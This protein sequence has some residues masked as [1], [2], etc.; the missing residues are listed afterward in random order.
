MS[1][2]NVLA[3]IKEQEVKFVDLRFTDTKGKEQHVSVPHHQ[4]DEGFFE[5]GKMFDGSSIAGWKGINESDMVLMPDASTALLDPFTEETTLIIRCDI[6]EPA[7]MQGYDRDPRSIAK[8]AEGFL[9]SSGIADTVLFGPEP[10]FF[11]FD[12]VRFGNTMGGSF[13]KVDAEE[14]AWN[15]ATEYEGGNKGHRPGVKG[16]YFPVAPVDSSQDLRSAMCLVLEEMGQVVEAHHHEVATAGQNEIATRFNTM[17]KKADEVQVQKYV[18]HNVAHAYG[19]TVTFMPKPMFGDNG[20]GMHCHQSLAK[21]GVNLFAGDLYGGLSETAL[22]YIGGIIK[23]AKA[24]NAFANPTTNSYKR[25]V[26]GYE[27]P[28]MLAYSARNRSASIRIPV[29]PSPKARRIEVRFP[30]PAANPYLAFAAQLMAGL[31]GIINK[32]HPGEAMDKNLYDLPP[33]EEALIPTVSG[34][35][36]EALK[37]LDADREFLTRGGVFTD[38]FIDSYLELKQVDVDRV[39]MTPHPVE[40]ELY[41]SV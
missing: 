24:I 32:I 30:D 9:K 38:D 8:R 33:E 21:D 37:S 17:T 16:G 23:H 19:K 31:D 13:F 27:A 22:F 20:S 29:V 41:Y 36:E 2:A 35:L 18:I 10:E 1:A 4:I 25:L 40:Y 28:V 3:L 26:P 11:I 15:S 39:R 34:S 12:D 6:L 5:D 14:A 7:T